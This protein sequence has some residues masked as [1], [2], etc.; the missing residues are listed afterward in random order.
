MIGADMA[1]AVAAPERFLLELI[2]CSL[3][4]GAMLALLPA[5]GGAIVPV[6][7][8]IGLAGTVGAFILAGPAPPAPPADLLSVAGAAAIAGELLVGLTLALALHASFAVAAI[9]GEW[10]AQAMGLGFATLVSPTGGPSSMLGV[11]L[12]LLMWAIFM[13]AGGHL[14][15]FQLIIESYRGLPSPGLLLE[16]PRLANIL[17]WGGFAIASG[18]IAALPLGGTLLLLNIILGVAARSAPQLNLF[19]VGFPLMLLTGLAGLPL[20]LPGIA[21]SFAGALV[22]LQRQLAG[23]LLG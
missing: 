13:N 15:L 12:G 11:M 4:A 19:A 10:I 16:A 22:E 7:V 1:A 23:V 2:W 20:A 18:L 3:R 6:Q 21:D 5:M 17:S 14:L 8:R 9:A